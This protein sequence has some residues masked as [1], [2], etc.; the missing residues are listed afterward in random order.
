MGLV[1]ERYSC[2]APQSV[3]DGYAASGC[4]AQ[5]DRGAVRCGIVGYEGAERFEQMAL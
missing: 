4:R 5:S 2:V 1:I 3:T